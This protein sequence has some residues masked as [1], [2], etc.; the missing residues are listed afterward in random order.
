MVA[1]PS[2]M[3]SLGTPAPEFSLP[4]TISGQTMSLDE[5]KSD[6]ATVVMF[7]CNH[8]PY[9]KHIQEGL[10]QIA[11]DYQPEGVSF[12]AISSNDVEQYP[13]DGPEA[14]KEVAQRLGYPF[15]YLFD[16]TQ[17]VAK[18][19]S[20]VCTPDIF[21]FDEEM[22]LVYRGQFDDARPS[23]NISVTGKDV[24]KAIDALLNDQPVDTQQKPS[25]GCS[26]K[27]KQ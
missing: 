10:I 4:D 18:A 17:E 27:W 2:T 3:V 11:Q 21:I 15:P 13:E 20:A 1:T 5:L 12:I 25:V 22:K 6:V 8:C 16:E 23:N 26:I 19:Y 9:V 24:R 14:M 7:I